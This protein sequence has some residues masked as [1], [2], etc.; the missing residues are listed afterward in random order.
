MLRLQHYANIC[1][2]STNT[3]F[4][5]ESAQ[6]K[7]FRFKHNHDFLLYSNVNTYMRSF[8]QQNDKIYFDCERSQ[9]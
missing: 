2:Y 3:F 8:R 9:E 5:T 4:T 1:F 7:F 6:I